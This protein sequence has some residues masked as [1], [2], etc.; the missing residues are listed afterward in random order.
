MKSRLTAIMWLAALAVATSVLTAYAGPNDLMD[1]GVGSYTD[2]SVGNQISTFTINRNMVSCGVGTVGASGFSGPFAMLM[3]AKDI[4]YYH[5]SNAAGTIQA[6]GTM[7]SITN[8][9]GA[10]VEDVVHRFVAI[11]VDERDSG[12]DRFDVHAMTP[13][14]NTGN[15]MCT[16]STVVQGGCRFGGELLPDMGD[17]TV[18]PPR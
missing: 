4:Q 15:P 7:R 14:W 2:P 11:A 16:P 17:V 8:V 10:T 5:V 1:E 3:Y 13:F 9:G 6:A 18:A 12:P